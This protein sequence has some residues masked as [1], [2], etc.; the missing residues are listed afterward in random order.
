MPGLLQ[1]GAALLR[2]PANEI[3]F[4]VRSL[5]RWQRGAPAVGEAA[6]GVERFGWAGARRAALL[7]RADE[8]ATRFDLDA[9]RS[10]PEELYGSNLARLDGLLRLAAQ[11]DVPAGEDGVVR[12]VDLG[13]GDFHYAVA[14]QQ[15]LARHRSAVGAAERRVVLRGFEVDGYGIYRDGH[16]RVDH[17]RE[18]AR[19]ASHGDSVVRIEVADATRLTLP[20]QDVVGL[21]FPFLTAYTCLRWGAPL[22]RS[23]PRRL[24]STAVRSLRAGGWLLVANQTPAEHARLCRLL[25]DLPVVRIARARLRSELCPGA[26]RTRGQVGSIWVRQ[27]GVPSRGA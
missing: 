14:L 12:A 9:L 6:A 8:L 5:L 20:E 11:H 26:E 7:A 24:L 18:W 16:S 19:R 1:S 17:A 25:R 4:A 21:F 3:A 23:R 10:A 2:A 15:F 22:S 13:C 27:P